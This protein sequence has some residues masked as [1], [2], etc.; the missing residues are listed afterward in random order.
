[1]NGITMIPALPLHLHSDI[2][3]MDSELTAHIYERVKDER[4]EENNYD[5]LKVIMNENR[6]S[7]EMED[8]KDPKFL[9]F[10]KYKYKV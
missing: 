5:E 2:N 3:R 10:M 9:T 7:V 1:M 4:I 6:A 8:L